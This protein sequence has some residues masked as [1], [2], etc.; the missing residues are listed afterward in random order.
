MSRFVDWIEP[1]DKYIV[2]EEGIVYRH[3]KDHDIP[4]KTTPRGRGYVGV[5]LNKKEYFVHRIVAQA[6]LNLDPSTNLQVNH[7]NGNK[8]DN[9]LSNLELVTP[10]ENVIHAYKTGLNRS[11]LSLDTATFIAEVP[12]PN[13]KNFGYKAWCDKLGISE[14]NVNR[15]RKLDRNYSEVSDNRLTKI[16]LDESPENRTYKVIVQEFYKKHPEFT[17]E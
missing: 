6:Y 3:Y 4:L 7:I 15:I 13:S 8:E 9:R 5:R 16:L 2:S 11:V 1:S 12:E 14:K 10:Q 17:E